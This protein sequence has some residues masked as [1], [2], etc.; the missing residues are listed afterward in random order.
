M[1]MNRLGKEVVEISDASVSFGDKHVLKNINWNIAPGERAGILGVNGAGKSTLLQLI[2]GALKPTAGQVKRGQTVQIATLTQQSHELDAIKDDR[3]REILSRKRNTYNVGGK[4]V[5]SSQLLERLGFSSAHLSSFV[6]ELSGGQKRRLQLL[7][8][9]LDE[10]NVLV[11]DEP[12]NDLDTD[13]LA[14]MEDLLDSW[15]GTLIVVSHDRYLMERITDNQYAVIDG[16]LR[17]LPGGVDQYID[18]RKHGE[19]SASHSN[20]S[21]NANSAGGKSGAPSTT[22]LSNAE[23]QAVT[24]EMASLEKKLAK[25]PAQITQA[26]NRIAAHDQQD[27]AGLAELAETLNQLQAKAADLETRWLELSDQLE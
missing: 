20:A 18:I 14:A 16:G 2:T 15:P 3:V 19:A 10:P 7:L 8:I 12:S 1:A 22:R 9:L 23:R 17:H 27:Y 6:K 13:M 26:N 11:M 25:V 21:G 5:S 4:E 24:K